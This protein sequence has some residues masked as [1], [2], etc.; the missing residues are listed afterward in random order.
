MV[1]HDCIVS[2]IIIKNV[3]F[4]VQSLI[5][6][7]VAHFIFDTEEGLSSSVLLAFIIH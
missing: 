1:D 2:A 5:A 3:F 4:F 7:I 6:C